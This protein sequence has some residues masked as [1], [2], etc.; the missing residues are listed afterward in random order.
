M[1]DH[2]VKRSPVHGASW[3]SEMSL[4]MSTI[5]KIEKLLIIIFAEDL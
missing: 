4:S 5:F 3:C 1:C 2:V